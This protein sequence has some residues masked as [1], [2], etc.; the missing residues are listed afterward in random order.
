VVV[1][2]AP[3]GGYIRICIARSMSWLRK[4][5]RHTPPVAPSDNACAAFLKTVLLLIYSALAITDMDLD[6]TRLVKH[7]D[8]RAS[9]Q[10]FSCICMG[11]CVRPVV[12]G[13][14][15]TVLGAAGGDDILAAGGGGG[16]PTGPG[17][18]L[19]ED[20]GRPARHKTQAMLYDEIL[21]LNMKCLS[22]ELMFVLQD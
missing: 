12:R 15:L 7:H 16:G 5:M 11:F 1:R 17:G 22:F 21:V 14:E 8:Y 10:A 20:G 3:G 6:S 4:A 2:G 19:G 13:N 18:G 9:K